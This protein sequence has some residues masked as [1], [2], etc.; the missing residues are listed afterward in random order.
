MPLNIFPV[1]IKDITPA[2]HGLLSRPGHEIR[3]TPTLVYFHGLN[4]SRNQI[5][6]DR[7]LEFAEAIRDLGVNLFSVDLR[8]HG[9]RRENKERPAIENLMKI[10]THKEKNPFYGAMED[11]KKIFDFLV[12]RKIAH[13]AKMAVAGLAWGGMHAL[14]ALR[15][16]RRLRCCIALL[17]VCKI[18][19]LVEFK[20]LEKHP[21]IQQFEPLNFLEKLAPKPLLIVTGEKD[22]RADPHFAAQLYEKLHP[23]YAVAEAEENLA[24]AMMLGAGHAYDSRLTQWTVEWLEKYLL[25]EEKGPMFE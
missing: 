19:S 23:E 2:I 21:L 25:A 1:T 12:D 8:G 10:I 18:T 20:G 3:T 16:E 17:P 14:Y 6:Q 4:G 15:Q 11:I 13:P 24:Y 5:F 9:E 7:Y 22:T